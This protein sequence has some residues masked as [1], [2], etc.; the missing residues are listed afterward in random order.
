MT[1][2]TEEMMNLV[3]EQRL[4]F[5]ATASKQGAPNVSPK[6]SIRVLDSGTL[7]FIDSRSEKTMRNLAENPLVA[8]DVFDFKAKKGFHFKG[9][10]EV[11]NKGHFFEQVV[12]DRRKN[13]PNL[14]PARNLILIHVEDVFPIA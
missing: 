4:A 11:T 14:R 1:T 7:Y 9:R 10:A 6:G 8:L 13:Q 5:V 12:E 2:M 3:T